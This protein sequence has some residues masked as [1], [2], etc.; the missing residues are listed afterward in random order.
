MRRRMG[1][2]ARQV[3]VSRFAGEAMAALH[4]E[5]YTALVRRRSGEISSQSA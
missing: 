2:V 3:A 1:S 4:A 5:L